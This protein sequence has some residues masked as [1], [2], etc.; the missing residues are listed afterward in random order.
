VLTKGHDVSCP[1]TG[2]LGVTPLE[3]YVLQG[4]PGNPFGITSFREAGGGGGPPGEG[5]KSEEGEAV[6]GNP[7]HAMHVQCSRLWGFVKG[8]VRVN[9]GTTA[10]PGESGGYRVKMVERRTI[11][12]E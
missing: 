9:M 6:L 2:G 10:K 7:S 4:L 1:P 3:S 5:R 12:S 11:G 8:N